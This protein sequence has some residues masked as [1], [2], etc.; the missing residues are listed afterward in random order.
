MRLPS[1][2]DLLRVPEQMR[3]FEHP[4]D[5]H[6]F[7]A[8]PPGSGKT[9]LAVYRARNL[10]NQGRTVCLI[11][12]NRMLAALARQL[13]DG[14]ASNTMHSFVASDYASRH[15][16]FV[17]QVEPYVFDW[18]QVFS[19][20]R[21]GGALPVF[22]HLIIDEAQNLPPG[23]FQWARAF[24]GRFLDVFAD[25]EQ[26]ISPER[27]SL[28]E[29]RDR[30]GLPDPFRLTLN[31]R[32]TPEIAEVAEHFHESAVRLAPGRVQRP[33]S[34]EIPGLIELS[35]F[36]DLV[37]RVVTRLRNRRESIGVIVQKVN[38]VDQVLGLVRGQLRAGERVDAYTS[39]TAAGAEAGIHIREPGVTIIT[40]ESAIGLEFDCVF[41]LDLARSLP[42]RDPADKRRMYMLCARA[43]DSL[44][45]VNGPEKLSAA[46]LDALPR[47]PTLRR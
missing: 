9:S 39:D 38:E 3:V 45:L 29:V 14:V 8:G 25:E 16:R 19:D 4:P 7:V 11:T 18:E 46:A 15:R 43:R 17:P 2:D 10:M 27:S 33:P 42:C 35:S 30:A 40:G 12:R 44:V 36:A 13:G 32:N 20:Y 22:D 34:G 41:L 26:A 6:L 23:F 47:P 1:L 24:G 31:H 28:Q 5:D 37:G 21:A